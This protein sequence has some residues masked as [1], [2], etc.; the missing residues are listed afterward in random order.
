MVLGNCLKVSAHHLSVVLLMKYYS[1]VWVLIHHLLL[2]LHHHLLLLVSLIDLLLLLSKML[3]I[4][5]R[6]GPTVHT[7]ILIL[8]LLLPVLSTAL[9]II[10]WLPCSVLIWSYII[11]CD[12]SLLG[13]LL[14]TVVH[15]WALSDWLAPS[16]IDAWCLVGMT[17]Y[18]L[19]PFCGRHGSSSVSVGTCLWNLIIFAIILPVNAIANWLATAHENREGP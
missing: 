8:L 4:L 7:L 16:V 12:I 1:I 15:V 5:R 17:M 11:R 19:L 10:L 6:E 9:G 13:L 18:A 14:G 3:R 2:L